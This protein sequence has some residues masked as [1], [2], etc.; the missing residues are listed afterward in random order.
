MDNEMIDWCAEKV[1]LA[2][3]SDNKSCKEAVIECIKAMREPTE[4]M[5]EAAKNS[6]DNIYGPKAVWECMID[7]IIGEE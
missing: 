4:K 1:R 2:L 5:V 3:Y 6:P 7:A